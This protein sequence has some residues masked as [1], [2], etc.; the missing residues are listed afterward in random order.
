MS[1]MDFIF[2]NYGFGIVAL[3]LT[4]I[5]FF[6]VVRFIVRW[7]EAEKGFTANKSLDRKDI[8]FSGRP[9]EDVLRFISDI[10]DLTGWIPER[11][12]TVLAVSRLRGNAGRWFRFR[13]FKAES[14]DWNTL[15]A[16]LLQQY[17]GISNKADLADE[18]FSKKFK[19]GEDFEHFVWEFRD[20]YLMWDPKAYEQD[21]IN[22][23]VKRLPGQ[24]PLLLMN[25]THLEDL[26]RKFGR[27]QDTESSAV[28]SASIEGVKRHSEPRARETFSSHTEPRRRPI[29]DSSGVQGTFTPTCYTCGQ[30]GHIAPMCPER[31]NTAGSTTP[32]SS[33][34]KCFRC[35][36]IGH[37]SRN[38]PDRPRVQ[39]RTHATA[40]TLNGAVD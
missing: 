18:L 33:R 37:A 39:N 5:L 4:V 3:L 28:R 12:R 6:I 32:T 21:I 29:R 10:E 20:L 22:A 2:R 25:V 11:E 35:Q 15:R 17:G 7:G 16:E 1:K 40:P 34:I 30:V 19:I 23:L 31:R 36:Q 8:S 9:D 26:T 38:C 27:Y 14:I 24:L 13:R